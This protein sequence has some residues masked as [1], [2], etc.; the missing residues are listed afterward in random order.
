MARTNYKKKRYYKQPNQKAMV[1]AVVKSELKK[2]IETKLFDCRLESSSIT[3][4]GS[5]L[6][7]LHDYYTTN[8][9]VQG[10]GDDDYIGTSIKPVGISI[11]LAL[12]ATTGSGYDYFNKFSVI[13]WQNIGLFNPVGNTLQN[14][15]QDTGYNES[16]LSPLDRQYNN[17]FRVLY[18]KEF[19]VGGMTTSIA[20]GLPFLRLVKI[21]IPAK[22]LRNVK[23]TDSLGNVEKGD[24]WLGII[25]DSGALLHPS[26]HG[27]WRVY[28]Q[29]A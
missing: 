11:K 15:Y 4:T 14:V 20:T 17:R 26:V 2:N 18:R 7:L 19:V 23:F 10:T 24:L 29:D 13:V 21:H 28:Y 16:P 12:E 5:A 1:K 25:S 8:N 6:R 22:K 3:S 27:A 9:I